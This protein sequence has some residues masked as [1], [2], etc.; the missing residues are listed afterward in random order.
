MAP[1]ATETV[2][3]PTEQVQKVRLTGNAGPY[4]ELAPIGYAKEAEL[5]GTDGHKAAQVCGIE[6]AWENLLTV[7]VSSLSAHMGQEPISATPTIRA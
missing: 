4:K 6:R 2:V 3:V 5:E 1:S 7:L